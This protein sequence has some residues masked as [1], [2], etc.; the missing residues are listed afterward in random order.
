M[1]DTPKTSNYT[2]LRVTK[3]PRKQHPFPKISSSEGLQKPVCQFQ[4]VAPY[5][6]LHEDL[7]L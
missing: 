2:I 1:K 4:F 3:I 7:S 5:F 6:E